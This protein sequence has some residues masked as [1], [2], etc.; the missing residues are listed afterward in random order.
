MK[1]HRL[2]LLLMTCSS[3]LSCVAQRIPTTSLAPDEPVFPIVETT[4]YTGV[5]VPEDYLGRKIPDP[6]RIERIIGIPAEGYWTPTPRDIERAE[7][8]IIRFLKD[9]QVVQSAN[10]GAVEAGVRPSV[11]ANPEI[12]KIAA[13]LHA[14]GRQYVGL[15]QSGDRR[16]LCNLFPKPLAE[17]KSW[18]SHIVVVDDGGFWYWRIVYDPRD[19]TCNQ[20]SSNGYA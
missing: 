16:V 5:I 1:M 4:E 3:M 15:I 11:P 6:R 7:A 17:D 10:E 14:Y 19:D 12:P 8:C 2:L 13:H 20:F 18:R 9:S